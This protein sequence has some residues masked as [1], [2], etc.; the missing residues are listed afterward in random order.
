MSKY[1]D[2]CIVISPESWRELLKPIII[3]EGAFMQNIRIKGE[4]V[5][6]HRS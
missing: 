6:V 5:N 3:D 4:V 2:P 1:Y